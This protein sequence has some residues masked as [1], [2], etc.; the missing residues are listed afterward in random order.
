MDWLND[1]LVLPLDVPLD[2]KAGDRVQVAFRYR[3]GASLQ[4]LARTLDVRVAGAA[5]QQVA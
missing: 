5:D 3:A 1:Y 2:V 4:S